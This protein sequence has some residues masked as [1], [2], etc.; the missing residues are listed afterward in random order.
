MSPAFTG[1]AFLLS[2][3]EEPVIGQGAATIETSKIPLGVRWTTLFLDFFVFLTLLPFLGA[4]FAC[5]GCLALVVHG[6]ARVPHSIGYSLLALAAFHVILLMGLG[7]AWLAHVMRM[8]A[9]GGED[10]MGSPWPRHPARVFISPMLLANEIFAIVY[11]LVWL[12]VKAMGLPT[13]WTWLG[14]WLAV[15][16]ASLRTRLWIAKKFPG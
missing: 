16:A 2:A 9:C 15:W 5:L 8:N 6:P 3:M 1:G 4:T 12:P 14:V 13:T 10:P 7:S 11:M